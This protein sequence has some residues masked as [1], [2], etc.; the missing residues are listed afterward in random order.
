MARITDHLEKCRPCFNQAEFQRSYLQM[1]E[2][3]KGQCCPDSLRRRVLDALR[4]PQQH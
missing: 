4:T 2:K 1:L 3:A